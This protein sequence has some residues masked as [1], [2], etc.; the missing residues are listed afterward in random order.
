MGSRLPDGPFAA[1]E[2]FQ[3]PAP[4]GSRGSI[5]RY[6]LAM[7]APRDPAGSSAQGRAQARGRSPMARRP[8]RHVA[9]SRTFLAGTAVAALVVASCGGGGEKAKP[10]TA[11]TTT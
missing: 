11:S 1:Q 4:T 6:D 2:S 8:R 3:V 10:S 5:G 7:F 9:W